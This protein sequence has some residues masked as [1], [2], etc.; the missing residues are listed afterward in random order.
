MEGDE[1]ILSVQK[2]GYGDVNEIKQLI[3]TRRCDNALDY[4]GNYLSFP[5]QRAC[6]R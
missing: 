1:A 3:Q 6:V 2:F 5:L 4:I